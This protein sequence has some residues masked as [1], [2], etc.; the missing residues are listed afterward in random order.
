MVEVAASSGKIVLEE[1]GKGSSPNKWRV[2]VGQTADKQEI[3]EHQEEEGVQGHQKEEGVE[4]KGEWEEV[5]PPAMEEETLVS[6]LQAGSNG[7]TML[8]EV[9]NA[10]CQIEAPNSHATGF[11]ARTNK[12]YCFMTAG[13]VFMK[14]GKWNETE[15]FPSLKDCSLLFGN[16]DGDPEGRSCKQA[17]YYL[18]LDCASASHDDL[19]PSLFQTLCHISCSSS[20]PCDCCSASC[21]RIWW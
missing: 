6:C 20:H 3:P 4:G 21:T 16:L 17:F 9:T 12:G 19:F 2:T 18:Y 5:Y 14:D 15:E 11:I 1:P 13:H 8:K 10:V 7:M